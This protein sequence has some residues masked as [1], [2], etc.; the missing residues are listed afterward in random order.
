MKDF[1]LGVDI[2]G[3]FT[4]IVLLRN[5]GALFSKKLLSTPADYSLAIEDGV[6]ELMRNS[7]V[8]GTRIGQFAHGTTVATNAIIERRGGFDVLAQHIFGVACAGLMHVKA[9]RAGGQVGHFALDKQAVGCFL[10]RGGSDGVSI[11]VD[12]CRSS[13]IGADGRL[14]RN[15]WR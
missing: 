1:S 14:L 6:G 9:V 11:R 2:G 12:E 10:D 8:E 13:N 4:D 5:D 15:R 3:T 7:K